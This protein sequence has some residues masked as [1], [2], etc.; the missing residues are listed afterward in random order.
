MGYNFRNS[1]ANLQVQPKRDSTT[2]DV[3][4][5]AFDDDDAVDEEVEGT[6]G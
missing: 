1:A 2:T 5:N 6:C 3:A 4:T